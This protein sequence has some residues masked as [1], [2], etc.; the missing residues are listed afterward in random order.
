MQ[1][2]LLVLLAL[3]APGVSQEGTPPPVRFSCGSQRG[4]GTLL[5]TSSESLFASARPERGT[6]VSLAE[7]YL[8]LHWQQSFEGN[9]RKYSLQREPV[10]FRVI[11]LAGCGPNRLV[12][13]GE[14][15]S[16]GTRIEV[17]K[18]DAGAI[19][20]DP[21]DGVSTEA[22]RYPTV[23]LPILSQRELFESGS[24]SVHSLWENPGKEHSVLVYTQAPPGG[25][26]EIWDLDVVRGSWTRILSSDP[27]STATFCPALN[28]LRHDRWGYCLDAGGRVFALGGPDSTFLYFF[29]ADGDGSLDLERTLHARYERF[30]ELHGEAVVDDP[31]LTLNTEGYRWV[32]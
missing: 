5:L 17:W 30:W 11:D 12:L 29:D 9:V 19:P 20:S 3:L 10:G 22:I 31:R 6:L 13:S 23:T 24:L 27:S 2:P 16:G 7:S 15:S 18:F 8:E 28:V 14:S 21:T 25:T 32:D 4:L 26:N 1:G